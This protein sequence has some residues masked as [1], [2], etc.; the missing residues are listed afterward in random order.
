MKKTILLSLFT[1]F[2]INLS[3][4]QTAYRQKIDLKGTWQYSFSA[5]SLMPSAA[6][7][8]DSLTLPEPQTP[9][10]RALLPRRKTAPTIS[11][12]CFPTSARRGIAV[13]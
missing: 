13:Q 9:T 12:D 11:P 2:I 5:D 7:F 10:A 4:Q 1:L 6:A 3:A 8:S